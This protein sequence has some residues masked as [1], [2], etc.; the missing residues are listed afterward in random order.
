[1]QVT[2]VPLI[3]LAVLAA[4]SAVSATVLLWHRGGRWRLPLRAAGV[5]LCESLIVL[6]AGLIVNRGQDFYPTWQALAGDT[7]T[8]SRTTARAAGDL[9]G[10]FGPGRLRTDWRPAGSAA[11]HLRSP[12]R[13]TVPGAYLGPAGAG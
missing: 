11:W 12:A 1:M 10:S 8:A 6:S 3:I 9:D 2:S 13:I 5:V 4:G 7:G